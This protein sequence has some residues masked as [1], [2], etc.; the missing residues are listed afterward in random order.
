MNVGSLRKRRQQWECWQGNANFFAGGR[1]VVGS[2]CRAL[3]FSATILLFT[4]TLFF[5]FIS[6]P[7]TT[8]GG[9]AFFSTVSVCLF[10]GCII[11]LAST[12]MMDP[13]IIPRRTLALWNSLDPASPDVAERK[14]CVT[15]QLARPPRAKHCKRCN[16]CVMEFDHHCPFTGNCI[17]ARNYRAF[18]AFI[19][20][21][22]ISEFFAC[23]LS[24][25]HI[26][27][28]RADN[29]GPVL[30]VNWAR[31]P[32]SQFFPHLLALW[33]A[34]V[35]VLVG[36]LLSFHIFLVAK[37]QTT[38]EYLRREAPSGSRLGRP[39]LSSCH[40]LWCGAR[41]PSLLSDMTESVNTDNSAGG[42]DDTNHD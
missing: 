17:G 42:T 37:G 33:T 29:V 7:A 20:I 31:I 34:V 26:V 5:T 8:Y 27:A 9:W 38:N 28:P 15:C 6:L 10:V 39:F 3:A 11:S 12:A 25:L 2:H 1:I 24:V 23:A 21:V 40:E 36:G 4:A 41:P 32:G 19:S 14:S 16:N 30:L 13:G 22:T 35:M 18:M